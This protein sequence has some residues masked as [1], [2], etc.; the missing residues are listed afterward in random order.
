MNIAYFIR[1]VIYFLIVIII[2]IVFAL[3]GLRKFPNFANIM[4]KIA[5]LY[6]NLDL[7]KEQHIVACFK[8][9]EN[10]FNSSKECVNLNY[11]DVN[12]DNDAKINSENN[13]NSG[14]S[15]YYNSNNNYCNVNGIKNIEEKNKFK[16]YAPPTQ[17]AILRK[18]YVACEGSKFVN[19]G[20]GAYV[21]NV[22]DL[23]ND[24]ILRASS[25]KFDFKFEDVDTPQV[26]I[27]HTH[28][29]ECY[30]SE[31]K[32]R[33]DKDFKARTKDAS[34]NVVAVGEE[35]LKALQ[36]NNIGA[37]HDTTIHDCPAY[38][39]SY[40]R[41][42][43]T[44]SSIMKKYPK[45][46]ILLDIHRDSITGKNGERIAPITTVNLDGET[47]QVAQVMLVCGCDDGTMDY[48]NYEKNLSFACAIQ[49]QLE[50]DY[51]NLAR[52]ISFKYK[53]YNQN[54]S[55]CAL[56]VEV[57][58]LANSIKEAKRA[59]RCFGLSLSRLILQNIDS[60]G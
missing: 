9:I 21:R 46:K 44:V 29:T 17:Y 14:G 54:L 2:S 57:G 16:G 3:F 8:N 4:G 12:D 23:P 33:Y 7:N 19:I 27:Y 1:K 43:F 31:E 22:T 47:K 38:M 40:D 30:E 28:T 5:L 58:S 36:D 50:K 45:I 32:D 20:G 53:D 11:V 41:S 51:K 24:V 35:I 52:P 25:G 15:G 42:N 49:R 13:N 39:G 6:L 37:L 18:C 48:K 60:G 55:S 34:K 26:L 10:C 59:G 56:L